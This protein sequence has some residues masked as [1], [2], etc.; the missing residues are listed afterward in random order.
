VQ[1][2]RQ[3][4]GVTSVPAST[5][6]SAA[7]TQGFFNQ[8]LGF[9]D[10]TPPAASF[11]A[12]P[13]PSPAAEQQPFYKRLLWSSEPVAAPTDPSANEP[14]TRPIPLPPRRQA[15]TPGG[16]APKPQASLA[17]PAG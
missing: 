14:S 4:E 15:I 2:A 11:A 7:E 6:A 10:P 9:S 13:R 16:A 17:P 8:I 3:S 12:S 5:P 1:R